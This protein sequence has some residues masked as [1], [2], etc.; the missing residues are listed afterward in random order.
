V[1]T[2]RKSILSGQTTVREINVTEAQLQLWM[3]GMVI[4]S[5]MPHLSKEDREYLI[6]G[7]TPEEWNTMVV[8]DDEPDDDL[9]HFIE[10]M[11]R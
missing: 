3:H 11:D 7:I 6:S 8:C 10:S 5:A 1:L 9:D 2:E 4:Q